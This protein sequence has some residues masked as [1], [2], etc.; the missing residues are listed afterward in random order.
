[1]EC[2]EK[3]FTVEIALNNKSKSRVKVKV[4]MA[5]IPRV[6]GKY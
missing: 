5:R 1:M 6:A 4:R 2:P 3:G